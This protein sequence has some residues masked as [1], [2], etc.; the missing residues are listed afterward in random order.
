M[1][2]RYTRQN[3]EKNKVLYERLLNLSKKHNCSPSQLAL[4]WVLHQGDNVVPIPG[5][6]FCDFYYKET[7]NA[8]ANHFL[9]STYFNS[10]KIATR[11]LL[12]AF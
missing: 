6:H 12:R 1:D 4:S 10:G 9:K 5:N 11:E 8:V 2:P 3:M 7:H